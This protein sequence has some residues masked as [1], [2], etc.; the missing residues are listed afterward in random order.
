MPSIELITVAGV[1]AVAHWKQLREQYDST[2]KHLVL[3]GSRRDYDAWCK[4]RVDSSSHAEILAEA[5]TVA[6][7]DWF[8]ER[9]NAE[10]D[11]SPADRDM[12]PSGPPEAIDIAAHLEPESGLPRAEALVG[13]VPCA[14]RRSRLGI[15]GAAGAIVP[16]PAEHKP[17]SCH[18]LD[19]TEPKW[20]RSRKTPLNV[21]P[22][23]RGSRRRDSLGQ[24]ADG[25]LR[26]N[27]RRRNSCA[28]NVAAGLHQPHLVL[29][30]ERER[31]GVSWLA[32]ITCVASF[33]RALRQHDADVGSGARHSQSVASSRT[34][35]DASPAWLVPIRTLRRD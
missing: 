17:P 16:G 24:G 6:F 35:K 11:P 13:L 32:V 7:P 23:R 5:R 18:W 8:L 26:I 1:D 14:I 27:H 10:L 31:A 3:L 25:L 9:R 12:W 21:M 4:R 15:A 28:A 34:P 33:R 20:C 30:V 19:N 29:L 22:D 2:G